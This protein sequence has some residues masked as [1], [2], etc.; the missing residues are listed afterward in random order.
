[1]Q[2]HPDEWLHIARVPADRAPALFVD[3]DGTII[4]N[5]PYLA[6]PEGVRLI[7]GAKETLRA[8][9]EAGFA[10]VIVSNQ[11]GV[12][13]GLC[14]KA[15]YRS[16]SA[17]VQALLEDAAAD[18]IYASPFHPAGSGEYAQTHLSRKPAPGMLLDAAARFGIEMVR[19]VMVGDSLVDIEAGAAAGVGF[20]VHLATGHGV[21]DAVAVAAFS[22]FTGR[23]VTSLP[24]IASLRPEL[25]RASS[26]A[27]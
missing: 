9:R 1:M 20:L 25:V 23:M 5:V 22:G 15:Q 7:P 19:S 27:V 4:Q 26:G 17:R 12:A 16:V 24:T 18:L 3:R 6:D 2:V 21:A 14:T 13:R 11:S 10:I 8:F